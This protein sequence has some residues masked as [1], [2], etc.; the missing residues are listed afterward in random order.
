MPLTLYRQ[1]VPLKCCAFCFGGVPLI[2]YGFWD[3]WRQQL[4]YKHRG[5]LKQKQ[6]G[7]TITLCHPCLSPCIKCRSH[8]DN[9][10]IAVPPDATAHLKYCILIITW[11]ANAQNQQSPI[12]R[13]VPSNPIM[14]H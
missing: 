1:T 6:Q 10:C 7:M 4:N 8:Y 5:K 3:V 13:Y 11:T 14:K 12:T 9:V 2:V